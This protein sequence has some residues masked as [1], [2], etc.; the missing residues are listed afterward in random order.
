MTAMFRIED[1]AR[2]YIAARTGAVT[3][4]LAFQP[5]IGG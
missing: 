2:R 5:A 1:D 4:H 3:I